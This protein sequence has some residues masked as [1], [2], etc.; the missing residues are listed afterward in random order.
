M[1]LEK[2]SLEGKVAIVTGGGSG[3]GKA[4]CLAMARAGADVVAAARRVELIEETAAE[5]RELGRRALAI[6]TDVTDSRQ[7]NQMVARTL[8]ELGRIDILVNNAG[9][10]RGELPRLIWDISDDDWRLGIDTNLSGAFYCSRAVAP[11]LVAQKSGKVINVASGW[12][13]RGVRHN[14]MYCCAKGGVIQLTRVLALSLARDNVQVNAIAPGFFATPR[15]ETPEVKEFFGDMVRFIPIGRGGSPHEIG[16]LAV[17]LASATS[18]YITGE[19][20]IIDG[21]GLAGG[22][23]PTGYAPVIPIKED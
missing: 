14:Y 17:L 19:V 18:D 15:L 10:V 13:L 12:G 16:P 8:S 4:M 21:G 6:P 5:V 23:A 1:V 11:H 22:Y 2:L 9:L 3:L 20:F 7:V